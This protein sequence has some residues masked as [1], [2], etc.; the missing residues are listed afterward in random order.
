M[1]RGDLQE[2]FVGYGTSRADVRTTLSA[3]VTGTIVAV[4]EGIRDGVRVV[5]GQRLL[6]I[7]ERDYRQQLVRAQS[8]AAGVVAGIAQLD[9][10]KRNLE[11]LLAIAEDEVAV[12]RAELKRF[13]DLLEI[14][15]AATT[16]V[17]QA[18]LTFQRSRRESQLYKN[19]IALIEPRR[20]VLEATR[21]ANLADARLAELA[22]EK[23]H[24]VAPFD[25][26]IDRV[27]VELGDHVRVG[28]EMI[29]I[30]ATRIIEVPI[31]LPA[32][33][34]PRLPSEA[35]CTLTVESMPGFLWRGR[36]SRVAPVTDER[37][38]TFAVYVEVDN[39]D[40]ETPLMP[41]H[42]LTAHIS[43]P[44]LAGVL[45]V[46]RGALVEQHVFV[47][48]DQVAVAREVH[49]DRYLQEKAIVSG[50]VEP[51]DLVILT[52]LDKMYD[53]AKVRVD[54]NDI[55]SGTMDMAIQSHKISL[56]GG[57]R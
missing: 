4:A 39:T 13:A 45:A 2:R 34:R 27:L 10:E 36:V 37:S 25:G 31:E 50:E 22:I 56:T 48:S 49:V 11:Q 38:R 8:V 28:S 24:V 12:N 17:D 33:V 55:A 1:S 18:R 43:G 54:A 40:Q 14:D 46:P 9:V 16:E 52:N 30:V 26:Q 3:Q 41:G 23:C 15:Q 6:D 5:K 20:A 21:D 51:G 19:Q 53:G 57:K 32:S 35:P 47:A 29:S 42:F 7:D 44:V